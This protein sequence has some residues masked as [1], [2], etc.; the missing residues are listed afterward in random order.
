MCFAA[1]M[2]LMAFQNCNP[3]PIQSNGKVQVSVGGDFSSTCP[4]NSTSSSCISATEKTC[5]VDGQTLDQGASIVT[6][7]KEIATNGSVC[8]SEVRVCSHGVLSGSYAYRNCRTLNCSEFYPQALCDVY[9]YLYG[10]WPD[11]VGVNFWGENF[12]NNNVPEACWYREVSQ[13]AQGADCESHKEI[14]GY[15]PSSSECPLTP[16]QDSPRARATSEC[17]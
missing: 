6:Y 2:M 15:Y 1:V 4:Q 7:E 8:Q 16:Q 10:R 14:F 5:F 11:E 9:D 13:G 17:P 12:Q 3:P